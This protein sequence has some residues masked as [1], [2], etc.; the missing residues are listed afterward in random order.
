MKFLLQIFAIFGCALSVVTFSSCSHESVA[1]GTGSNAG[2]TE[3]AG[4]ITVTHS[5]GEPLA[6][7]FGF[8]KKIR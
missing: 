7:A 3:L 4:I 5:N 8:C 2:E 6:H 1:N